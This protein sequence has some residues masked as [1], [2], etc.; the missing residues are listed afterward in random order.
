VYEVRESKCN[1]K[2]KYHGSSTSSIVRYI[3]QC[4]DKKKNGKLN[5]L[6]S[7]TVLR[8]WLLRGIGEQETIEL[9]EMVHS[10]KID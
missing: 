5:E 2:E 7:Y 1:K 10:E 4:I 6:A 3:L 9:N 8:G